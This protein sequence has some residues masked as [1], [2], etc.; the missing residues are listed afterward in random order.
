M[1]DPLAS[2]IRAHRFY[3]RLG[4]RSVEQRWFDC[5]DCFVFRLERTDWKNKS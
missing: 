4:F 2:N 3:Q 1:V 5:D